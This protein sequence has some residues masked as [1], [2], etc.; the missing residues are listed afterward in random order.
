MKNEHSANGEPNALILTIPIEKDSLIPPKR[1]NINQQTV[2]KLFA[3]GESNA[4]IIAMLIEQNF[5][6]LQ[7]KYY[8]DLLMCSTNRQFVNFSLIKNN[9][10]ISVDNNQFF[11]LGVTG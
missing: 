1:N 10:A 2:I 11:R 8:G 6:I 9:T 5:L 4:M 3:N 7:N